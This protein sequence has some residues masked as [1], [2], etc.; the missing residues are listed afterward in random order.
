MSSHDRTLVQSLMLDTDRKTPEH[1]QICTYLAKPDVMRA[2]LSATVAKKALEYEWKNGK[3]VEW[4]GHIIPEVLETS[5]AELT[6]ISL[7]RERMITKGIGQ[8]QTLIGFAD[9]VTT[10]RVSTHGRWRIPVKPEAPEATHKHS[11]IPYTD[12]Q[13]RAKENEAARLVAE[14][15]MK[16]MSQEDMYALSLKTGTRDIIHDGAIIEVKSKLV[17]VADAVR[18][19]KLY[20]QYCGL[21]VMN[22]ILASPSDVTANDMA[23]L[24]SEGIT[25]VKVSDAYREKSPIVFCVTV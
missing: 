18:Q 25:Y 21:G 10:Y 8:Y 7:V 3:D 16:G 6:K 13:A 22:L 17:N 15:D 4:W 2:L 24:N 11:N 12:Y 14:N 1:D 23:F 5:P 19:L 20:H 9:I